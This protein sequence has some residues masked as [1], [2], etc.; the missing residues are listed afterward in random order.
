VVVLADNEHHNK[1]TVKEIMNKSPR[2]VAEKSILLVGTPSP[3]LKRRQRLLQSAGLDVVCSDN[4]C[5]AE[6]LSES[7]YFDG[8]LYDDSVPAHEQVSLAR[9]MRVRWPWMRLVRYGHA[10]MEERSDGLFDASQPS[11]AEL[12]TTL[13]NL[14]A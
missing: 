11:E 14:L 4:V 1:G 3:S 6:V 7:H 5:T 2:V 10:T 9:V 12:A 8:A 13:K